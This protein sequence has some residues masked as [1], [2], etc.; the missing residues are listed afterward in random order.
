MARSARLLRGLASSSLKSPDY[1][2]GIADLSQAVIEVSESQ[3]AEVSEHLAADFDAEQRIH[4]ARRW[5]AVARGRLAWL[6][7]T[8]DQTELREQA[9]TKIRPVDLAVLAVRSLE[10]LVLDS[11]RGV[12]KAGDSNASVFLMDRGEA[13]KSH[14]AT[15]MDAGDFKSAIER[16]LIAQSNLDPKDSV[17]KADLSAVL[18]QFQVAYA[19][20]E[21]PFRMK[22]PI[23]SVRPC[24]QE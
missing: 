3:F 15:L 18:E 14:V 1:E 22:S 11:Q 24:P 16:I 20:K 12:V 10:E 19:K 23:G 6:V 7:A 4:W 2:N 21:L 13:W 8:C 17:W 9:K 5:V